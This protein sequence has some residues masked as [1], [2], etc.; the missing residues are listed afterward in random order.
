MRK[1]RW[2]LEIARELAPLVARVRDVTARG[3]PARDTRAG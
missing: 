2:L 3:D 1:Y